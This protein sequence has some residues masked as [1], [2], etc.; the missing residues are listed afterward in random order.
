MARGSDGGNRP[1]TTTSNPEASTPSPPYSWGRA[2]SGRIAAST[3]AR[4]SARARLHRRRRAH[5]WV[6]RRAMRIPRSSAS[7][8]PMSA[9]T[10]GAGRRTS[11]MPFDGSPV[12]SVARSAS[13]LHDRP[14]AARDA[15]LLPHLDEQRVE[16]AAERVVLQLLGGGVADAHGRDRAQPSMQG[17]S[18]SSGTGAPSTS[19]TGA[20][21]DAFGPECLQEGHGSVH[22]LGPAE[23]R[24]D[25]DRGGAVAQPRE[26][27]VELTVPARDLGQRRRGRGDHRAGEAIAACVDDGQGVLARVPSAWTEACTARGLRAAPSR[28]ARTPRRSPRARAAG[29]D[30]AARDAPTSPARHEASSAPCRLGRTWSKRR[31]V[32]G[33]GRCRPPSTL[34]PTPTRESRTRRGGWRARPAAVR[35]RH[36]TSRTRSLPPSQAS[37]PSHTSTVTPSMRSV[38]HAVGPAGSSPCLHELRVDEPGLAPVT[39]EER[40]RERWR[41]HP[42]PAPPVDLGEGGEQGG[43]ATVGQE[44][45][46]RD[47]WW[48]VGREPRDVVGGR[49]DGAKRG[50]APSPRTRGNPAGRGRSGGGTPRCSPP[51]RTAARRAPWARGSGPHTTC[52]GTAAA[53]LCARDRGDVGGQRQLAEDATGNGGVRPPVRGRR[54][55]VGLGVGP[56]HVELGQARARPRPPLCSKA[57]TRS[58]AGVTPIIASATRPRSAPC[59]SRSQ[60]PRSAAACRAA[61]GS[62]ARSTRKWSHSRVTVLPV[63]Q[64]A[65]HADACRAAPCAAPWPPATVARSCAR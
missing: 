41:V 17:I 47:R 22:G 59:G 53:S 45:V 8:R 14:L 24:C 12:R 7:Q 46:L 3:R 20:A 2:P 48:P 27:I 6:V 18:R 60:P 56:T 49:H 55:R 58:A 43:G 52:L 64:V 21:K 40:P 34:R 32:P 61:S 42:R 15:A 1:K 39:V 51:P 19:V 16:H 63:E 10:S 36:R 44:P 5:G 62:V 57:S 4:A 29:R 11:Q 25:R 9:D 33:G 26:P 54:Q 28:R 30:P 37:I 65:Y 35:R 50:T 23:Q 13:A 31:T 38:V